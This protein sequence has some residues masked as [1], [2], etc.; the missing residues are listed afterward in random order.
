MEGKKNMKNYVKQAIQLFKIQ[1]LTSK[2]HASK[3]TG[4]HFDET[5]D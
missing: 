4:F 2:E 5:S 3:G 1:A